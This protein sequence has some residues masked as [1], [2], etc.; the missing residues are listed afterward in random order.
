M[1]FYIMDDFVTDIR[2]ALHRL[3]DWMY[4]D[5]I[6]HALYRAYVKQSHD[7]CGKP[8]APDIFKDFKSFELLYIISFIIKYRSCSF[9]ISDSSDSIWESQPFTLLDTL[10]SLQHVLMTFISFI[11]F[12]KS[13]KLLRVLITELLYQIVISQIIG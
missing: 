8:D 9:C 12:P 1:D 3:R 7:V 4:P 2:P 13:V 11:T 6:D 5:H 10:P